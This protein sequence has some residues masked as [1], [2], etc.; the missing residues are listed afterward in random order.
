MLVEASPFFVASGPIKVL[1]RFGLAVSQPVGRGLLLG[2]KPFGPFARGAKVSDGG[3]TETFANSGESAV[4][5]CP[6][7][8]QY[9]NTGKI[10]VPEI[11]P[12]VS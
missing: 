1:S 4:A 3:H 12:G 8:H 7:H 11:T 9:S 6:R 5:R 10:N 2:H